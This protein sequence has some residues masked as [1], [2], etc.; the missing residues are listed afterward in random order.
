M[1]KFILLLSPLLFLVGCSTPDQYYRLDSPA[2]PDA[3][4]S[5][6][7]TGIGPV[8]IPAYIDRP[9]LVFE[10]ATGELQVPEGHRWSGPVKDEITRVL[11]AGIQAQKPRT[12]VLAYPWSPGTDLARRIPVS[13]TELTARS[14]VGVTLSATWEIGTTQRRA[15]IQQPIE[16]DGYPAI[17]NAQSAALQQ[18]AQR[19]AASY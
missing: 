8:S 6:L 14:G 1:K 16:G 15:T 7:P 18:L 19:I 13:I 12:P 17:T 10:S 9:E 4:T 11:T 3:T 5:G 2:V